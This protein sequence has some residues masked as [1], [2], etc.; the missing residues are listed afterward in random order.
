MKYLNKISLLFAFLFIGFSCDLTDLDQLDNPNAVTAKNADVDL[1][2]N[3]IQVNFASYFG[4]TQGT[5]MQL[6]RMTS[7]FGNN[8]QAAYTPNGFNWR[9]NMA[10]AYIIPDIDAMNALATEKKQFFHV[11]AAKIIK[12]YTLHGK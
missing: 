10:Y 1:Y 9:W 5:G 4:G 7:M 8:Y 11:G 6:A 2:F 3:E 12:A